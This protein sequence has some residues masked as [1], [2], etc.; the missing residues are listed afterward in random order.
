MS[1]LKVAIIDYQLSNLFSVQHA[2]DYVGLKAKITSNPEDISKADALILPGVGAFGDAMKN[3]K[4]FKL[5]N[6]IL[7]SIKINKPFLGICLGLQLLFEK[8][9]EFGQNQGLGVI[10]G[11]VIKFRSFT[12]NGDKIRIPQIGWNKINIVN[13]NPYLNGIK[14]EE[15]M[16]FVHSYYVSPENKKII[17]TNTL[18]EDINYVSAVSQKNVFAVQFHPERSGIEGL[19]I[20]QNFSKLI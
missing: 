16:Y 12:K 19:K 20:Y 11:K 18:Y 4:K 17:V 7:Q 2:C 10:K 3:L 5:I 1:D 6:P 14:N 13:K 8:S 9:E 15:F